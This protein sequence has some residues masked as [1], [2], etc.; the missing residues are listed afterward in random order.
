M[1]PI[2]LERDTWSETLRALSGECAGGA[3]H[4]RS[5]G[6]D[7]SL[8]RPSPLCMSLRRLRFHDERR[9]LEL[10]VALEGCADASLRCFV[11]DPQR[12]LWLPSRHGH[13]LLVFDRSQAQTLIQLRPAKVC[14]PTQRQPGPTVP[15]PKRRS[16]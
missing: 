13:A 10:A 1:K 5:S 14:H 2:E 12:I 7:G 3:A 9:E 4:V 6:A 11:A 8:S 15:R 16:R